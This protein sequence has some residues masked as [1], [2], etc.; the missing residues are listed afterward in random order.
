METITMTNLPFDLGQVRS[1]TATFE[2][3]QKA[4]EILSDAAI[5][6][7]GRVMAKDTMI[8]IQQIIIYCRQSRKYQRDAIPSDKEIT[9]RFGGEWETAFKILS[10]I[11][12]QQV[13]A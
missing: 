3:W 6:I 13:K 7:E 11:N 8:C 4:L 12:F 2:N 10:E 9:V 5:H 1:A